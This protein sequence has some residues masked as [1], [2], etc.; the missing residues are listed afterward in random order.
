[1]RFGIRPHLIAGDTAHEAWAA[2]RR[3]LDALD[4]TRSHATGNVLSTSWSM[5]SGGRPFGDTDRAIGIPEA[6][7]DPCDNDP[8]LL[9]G[10]PLD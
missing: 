8:R 4:P 1:V 6:P 5:S 10:T 9:F 3:L 2:A 7:Y